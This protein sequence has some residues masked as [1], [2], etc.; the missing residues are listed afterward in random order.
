MNED[1]GWG[2]LTF[3]SIVLMVA[4]VMRFLDGIWAIRTDAKV[5]DLND[6]LL[7]EELSAYGW[8]YLIVGILLILCGIG[9]YQR[10]QLSRWIG[11]IAGALLSI[12]AT[13]WLPFAPVWALVYIFIGIFLIYGLA[14]Y[15]G[16]VE[17]VP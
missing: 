11:I 1:D 4:G 14:V 10:S 17:Q 13:L 5:P 16:R 6:Q 2:W 9:V 8:V 12:S 7:G 15:G 3:A